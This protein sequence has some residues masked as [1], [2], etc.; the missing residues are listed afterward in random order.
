MD[1]HDLIQ[2]MYAHRTEAEQLLD[3]SA[4]DGTQHAMYLVAKAQAHATL[5]ISY[6]IQAAEQLSP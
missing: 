3:R 1:T 5:A 4:V 6:T 2:K